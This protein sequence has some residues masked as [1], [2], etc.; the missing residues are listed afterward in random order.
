MEN[1][2]TRKKKEKK[3]GELS[4]VFFSGDRTTVGLLP[5]NT[6]YGGRRHEIGLF[7]TRFSSPTLNLQS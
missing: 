2:V 7:S 1:K 4:R 6:A 5:T 3:R